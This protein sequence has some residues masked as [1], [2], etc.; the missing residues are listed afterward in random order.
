FGLLLFGVLGLQAQ[1]SIQTQA[2]D[3]TLDANQ[4]QKTK[5]LSMADSA[6]VA[7]SLE[8]ISLLKQLDGLRAN[9]RAEKAKLQARL[10]S[11]ATAK[12][13]RDSLN[14][15]QIDSLRSSTVGVPVVFY[16]D[17]LLFIYS[18]LG[19]FSPTDRA[20]RIKE[21]LEKI[22]DD[23][24]Y[25]PAQFNLF[26][27]DNAYDLLYEDMIIL[28]VNERDA[29]WQDMPLKE[30]SQSYFDKIT[31][32][33]DA[34]REDTS[35]YK[36]GFRIGLIFLVALILYILVRLLNKGFSALVAR[37]AKS[38]NKYMRGIKLKDYEFLSPERQ[39]AAITWCMNIGKWILIL[40]IV[41]LSLP[42]VFSIFPTTEGFSRKLIGY[43]A[44]VYI[45]IKS[46]LSSR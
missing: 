9:D 24:T 10:D 42:V 39:L 38:S 36:T 22:A 20:N 35:I 30:L 7:D 41:Y 43:V 3:A 19:P 28:S 32:S 12:T 15:A 2:Q 13:Q 46:D 31:Q 18:K 8:K 40:L 11:M 26:A 27:G 23:S 44:D 6:R 14:K 33:V 34:Y 4:E 5:L 1:D 45:P 25:D 16:K 29:F 37:I 17:T 21:K